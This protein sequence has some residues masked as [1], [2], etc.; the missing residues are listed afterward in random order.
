MSIPKSFWQAIQLSQAEVRWVCVC[1]YVC[2][3]KWQN[4]PV[5]LAQGDDITCAH[6]NTLPPLHTANTLY[7]F[8]G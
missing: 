6:S 2:V 3:L 4:V 7:R 5:S 1:M 8:L